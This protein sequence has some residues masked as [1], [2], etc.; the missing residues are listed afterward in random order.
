MNAEELN[1]ISTPDLIN[2]LSRRT[3]EVKYIL[4]DSTETGC[5]NVYLKTGYLA[6]QV[7]IKSG[8][9]RILIVGGKTGVWDRFPLDLK[10]E[11]KETV[12]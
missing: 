2:E 8:P 9:A 11:Q 3:S 4:V 7:D 6:R 5:C 10:P 1:R 12:K